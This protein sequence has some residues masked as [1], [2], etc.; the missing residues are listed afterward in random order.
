MQVTLEK[1]GMQ[2]ATVYPVHSDR[3]LYLVE[4]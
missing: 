2:P 4:E 3:Y 1:S